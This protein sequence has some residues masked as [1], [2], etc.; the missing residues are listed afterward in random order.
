MCRIGYAEWDRD[1]LFG[2]A[3]DPTGYIDLALP[4]AGGSL[5]AKLNCKTLPRGSIRA[6]VPGVE[7]C[8]LDNS[9]PIAGNHLAA[10]VRWKGGPEIP[11]EANG[12]QV[13]RLHL[14]E[15][16]VYAFEFAEPSAP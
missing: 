4:A 7:S 2:F 8:S 9:L 14:D 12:G 3:S 15:A 16:T 6:E 11:A 5:R 10:E 1:R 13:L